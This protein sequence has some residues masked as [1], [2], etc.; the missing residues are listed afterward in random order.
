MS[1]KF[2]TELSRNF[3]VGKEQD[4]SFKKIQGS[5]FNIP[6]IK[7]CGLYIHVPFCKSICPYC[8]YNK[9]LYKTKLAQA[10]VQALCK[11]IKLYSDLLGPIEISSI[12]IGGGTPTTII[13]DL[14]K[15]LNLIKEKFNLTGDIGI[16]TSVADITC[17]NIKIFKSC[18]V[19]L[20][21]IGV[22]SFNDKF[23]KFLGRNYCAKDISTAIKFAKE[24]YFKTVNIDLMFALENQNINDICY[25]LEKA[26]SSGVD[27]I[28]T[29]PLFTFPYTSVGKF[30]N[31]KSL[32]MP[33]LFMRKKMYFYIYDF[34]LNNKFSPVSVWGFKK[35]DVPRYSSV[36]RDFYIGLGAGAASSFPEIFYF[37]T[38][39]VPE[40]NKCLMDNNLPYALYMPVSFNLSRYYWWYWRLYETCFFE[41]DFYEIFGND[42]KAQYFLKF[43][44]LMRW[45]E[46]NCDTIKL[47]R[48]GAF[49]VHL[50]QNYF[51]LNYINKVWS[52][53]MNAPWPEYIKI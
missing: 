46:K 26:I 35:G 53:A 6:K 16:E 52:I 14:E 17:D 20:L 5:N 18:G 19:N 27:Q 50:I 7:K 30:L 37:N 2:F 24:G 42:K 9:I 4:F 22:Q 25:D 23:L 33:N 47:T 3:F 10:Y 28:T 31:L 40:Y 29:Y 15:I 21:S 32:K 38:F 43:F 36:T 34:M 12:Y 11:E 48:E 13:N 1:I 45:C 49:W 51:I 44:Y 39:S 41:K 8:P